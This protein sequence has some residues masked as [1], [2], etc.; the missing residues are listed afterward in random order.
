VLAPRSQ[1][2]GERLADERHLGLLIGAPVALGRVVLRPGRAAG[3]PF[4]AL[5]DPGQA[6]DVAPDHRCREAR[7]L[8]LLAHAGRATGGGP[9][10][11]VLQ[12]DVGEDAGA[13]QVALREQPREV[14]GGDAIERAPQPGLEGNALVRREHQRVEK[15]LAELHVTGPDPARLE[16][17]EGGHVD[18]HR[19]GTA[20]LDVVGAGVLED[21]SLVEGPLH[22]LELQQRRPSQHAERPLI[23]IR[24]PRDAL[25]PEQPGPAQGELGQLLGRRIDALGAHDLALVHQR[26]EEPGPGERLPIRQGTGAQHAIDTPAQVE[27]AAVSVA[28]RPRLKQRARHGPACRRRSARQSGAR[29]S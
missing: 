16:A 17:L 25:V 21:E 13:H 8:D 24:D 23:G 7:A 15:E 27:N 4:E 6:L 10:E 11:P 28:I 19:L 22:E 9:L 20:P 2:S 12:V 14:L 29:R 18:E 1:T 26:R 3:P 5:D